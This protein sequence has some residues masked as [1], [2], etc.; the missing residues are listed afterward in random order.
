MNG[1]MLSAGETAVSRKSKSTSHSLDLW[2]TVE[3]LAERERSEG[4]I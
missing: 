2:H 1:I 4:K 3:G